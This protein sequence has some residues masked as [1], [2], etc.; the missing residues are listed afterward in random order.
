MANHGFILDWLKFISGW[1]LVLYV[2]LVLK[3]PN[4]LLAVVGGLI[5]ATARI[6]IYFTKPGQAFKLK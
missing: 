6:K 2:I 1:I 3:D 4:N 5:I